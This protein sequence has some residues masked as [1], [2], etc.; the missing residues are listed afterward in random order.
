LKLTP[1]AVKTLRSLPPQFGQT[2]S[3]S[4]VK[5]CWMSKAVPHSVH[6]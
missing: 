1:M 5:A 4:S 2:V 6:L 3:E